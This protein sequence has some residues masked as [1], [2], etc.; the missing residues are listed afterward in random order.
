MKIPPL[1]VTTNHDVKN[2]Q[3]LMYLHSR[4]Y[5]VHFPNKMPLTDQGKPLYEINDCTWKCFFRKLANQ[6][7]LTLPD[8]ENGVAGRSFQCCSRSSP[9]LN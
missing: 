5:C 8:K 1:L 6:L 7:E 9:E 3:T 2:D 4:I